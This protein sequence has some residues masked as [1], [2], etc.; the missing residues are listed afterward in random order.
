MK[1]KNNTRLIKKPHK[2][3]IKDFHFEIKKILFI[4]EF[5]NFITQ[6]YLFLFMITKQYKKKIFEFNFFF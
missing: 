6:I 5:S 3:L 2:N 4:S 1:N